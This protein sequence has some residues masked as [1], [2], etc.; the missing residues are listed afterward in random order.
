MQGSP[1]L[2]SAKGKVISK[3]EWRSESV[4]KQ[5][6]R[7]S[8]VHEYEVEFECP[9]GEGEVS[10]RTAILPSYALISPEKY[11]EWRRSWSRIVAD[12]AREVGLEVGKTVYAS[13]EFPADEETGTPEVRR[14]PQ[15]QPYHMQPQLRLWNRNRY[16]KPKTC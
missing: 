1:V 15:P 3:R 14:K 6:G 11:D 13:R 4:F 16:V 9:D 7:R 10:Q 2:W 12:Y 5:R 8:G